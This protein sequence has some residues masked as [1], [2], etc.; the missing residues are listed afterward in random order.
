MKNQVAINY[1]NILN[2]VEKAAEKNSR[3]P[4]EIRIIVVTKNRS[5]DLIQAAIDAGIRL[6]GENYPE[7][8]DQKFGLLK[9]PDGIE[10]HMIGHL[11]SRK[12]NTLCE[13]FSYFHS[14]D[15][16]SVAIKLDRIL[17]MM[18]KNLPVLLEVN[19]GG[20]ETKHGWPLFNDE[21]L[22]PF[23]NDIEILKTLKNI[24]IRG[25]MTM[26]PYSEDGESSR[27]H[28]KNLAILQMQ[29]K[30]HFPQFG[31]GELSMGTSSDYRQAIE[32]GAT[33]IR[34]GTAIFGPRN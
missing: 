21:H 22:D 20:E 24:E 34:L 19:T 3:N 31:W 26:P 32:E 33:F 6:F 9:Q 1:Q 2:Q 15:R 5:L 12:I 8:L 10:W 27:K 25:L 11:Q 14:L 13:Y 23:I 18:G 7:D 28:F 29:L 4:S 17:E 16:V 30:D